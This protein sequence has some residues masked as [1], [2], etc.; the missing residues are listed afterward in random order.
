MPKLTGARISMQNYRW[1]R[2]R[3]YGFVVNNGDAPNSANW[4]AHSGEPLGHYRAR[5]LLRSR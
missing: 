1:R 5:I 4:L 3:L 2:L